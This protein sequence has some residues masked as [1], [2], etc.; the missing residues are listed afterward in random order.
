MDPGFSKE[1]F[2]EVLQEIGETHMPFGKYGP[3]HF[4]PDGIPI[5]DLPAEYLYYFKVK[6]FPKD[7]LGD[8]LEM[9]Y[10]AKVDGADAAFDGLRLAAGG[11]RPLRKPRRR[12]F[13]PGEGA[14]Q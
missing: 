11:R 10:H 2:R 8:L 13:R 1:E 9:V 7:R 5:Y 4:P 12:E 14:D 6:G 3:E